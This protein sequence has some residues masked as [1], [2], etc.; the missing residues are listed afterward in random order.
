MRRKCNILIFEDDAQNRQLYHDA[1]KAKGFEVAFRS[2]AEG[3]F[4]DEVAHLLP[5][6]ISMDLMMGGGKDDD[7]LDGFVA[8]RMLKAD[9]RTQKIPVIVL[10]SFFEENKVQRAKELG[11]VDF[12]SV[13]GQSFPKIP[14]HFLR[15]LKDPKHYKSSHSVFRKS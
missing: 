15:Y 1:F 14:D 3:Q 4:L 7:E 9:P 8:L 11:A 10:T 5:D 6:I 12:I 13:P 2:N